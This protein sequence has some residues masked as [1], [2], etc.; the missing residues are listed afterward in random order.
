MSKSKVKSTEACSAIFEI[1]V[2][3]ESVDK[4]FE[5][6][7]GEITKVAQIPG[8]RAGK[9][10]VELV[11][12]NY[13]KNAS[14]EALK[15]ILPDAYTAALKDHGIIPVSA[16]EISD[17]IFEEGKAMS[18]KA[19]VDT[20][21]K[22]GLKNYKG[23]AITRKKVKIEPSDIDKT[24]DNVRQMHAKYESPEDRPLK[25]GDY[26]VS[27]LDCLVDGK[28]IH[29]KREDL[30]LFLDKDTIALGLSDGMVGMKKGE[31][32]D[33]EVTLSKDYPNKDLAGK[34]SVYH[35]KV[36][37]I[38][39]RKLPDIDD[40]LAKE[41]GK[42]SLD[43]LRKDIEEGLKEQAKRNS[44]IEV[45]NNVLTKLIDDNDFAVPAGF[46]KRQLAHM[47]ENAKRRLEEK[48]FPKGELDKKDEELNKK[49]KDDAVRRVRLL[50]ILDAIAR[51]EKIDVDEKDLEEAYR[52]IASQS[53][54]PESE[55]KAHYEKEDIVDDLKEQLREGKTIEFLINNAKITE[56]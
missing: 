10:P 24:L 9:A 35:V 42:D 33:I 26:A 45:E 51:A 23:I 8:F 31:E 16:P 12:K 48:G 18:F 44:D 17:L 55:V 30:W 1:E 56:A 11:K 4:A 50:F 27:D 36:K 19:R 39:V 20:R 38:K 5:E 43:A 34:K 41:L 3:K 22:F 54:K 21:P 13:S 28:P 47:V 32:R 14:E 37:D 46:V 7:Y 25:M 15:R 40:A 2:P 52:A 53:G 6:V 49:F 29:R